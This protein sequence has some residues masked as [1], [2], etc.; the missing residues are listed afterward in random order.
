MKVIFKMA[1]DLEKENNIDDKEKDIKKDKDQFLIFE[2]E[3]KNGLRNGKGKEYKDG[4]LIYEGEY[5]NGLRISD[6]E[7][8]IDNSIINNKDMD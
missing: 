3:Y 8:K 7:K 5:L 2:G 6:I 1:K 4:E